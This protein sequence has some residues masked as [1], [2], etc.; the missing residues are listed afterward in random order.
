MKLLISTEHRF[1][2]ART[3]SVWTQT[4]FRYAFWQRYCSVFHSVA[5]FA[6]VQEVDEP[7]PGYVR[8]DGPGVSFVALPHYI[9][10]VRYLSR[11]LTIRRTAARA[12]ADPTAVILRVPSVIANHLAGIL[13]RR[14]QPY[15][16]EVVG[17]PYDVFAPGV[18]EHPLRPFFRWSFCRALRLQC[19]GA[20]AAAYVT[21]E[22]LQLRYHPGGPAFHIS[23][24]DLTDDHSY[25]ENGNR[26]LV[27]SLP[28]VET[29][30]PFRSARCPI[31]RP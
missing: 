31:A 23:D 25:T 21:A 19:A 6:R 26:T 11:W 14:R 8:A 15:G 3:G 4:A 29:L 24:V 13:W 22:A 7:P 1:I 18:V 10:P 2:S 9:G 16:V 12:L 30:E 20:C 5:V 28:S 27:T 17:D